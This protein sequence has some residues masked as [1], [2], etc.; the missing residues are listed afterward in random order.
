MGLDFPFGIYI[1]E[2]AVQIFSIVTVI[3]PRNGETTYIIQWD[4][5]PQSW[6]LGIFLN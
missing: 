1:G 5:N 4:K 3:E 6:R 2:C